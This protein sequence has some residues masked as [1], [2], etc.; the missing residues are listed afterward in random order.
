MSTKDEE[1]T[2]FQRPE[3]SQSSSTFSRLV[4]F[5]ATSIN[6]QGSVPSNSYASQ[7]SQQPYPLPDVWHGEVWYPVPPQGTMPS[8][9]SLQHSSYPGTQSILGGRPHTTLYTGFTGF[10]TVR[11]LYLFAIVFGILTDSFMM[12]HI[13]NYVVSKVTRL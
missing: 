10:P 13:P 3:G 9:A 8:H 12:I 7:Q 5:A 6:M 4:I 1:R 11:N 2:C